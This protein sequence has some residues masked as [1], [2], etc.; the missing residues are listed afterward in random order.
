MTVLALVAGADA[1][2]VILHHLVRMI[3]VI[4]GAPIAARLAGVGPRVGPGGA[5]K[6]RTRD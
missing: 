4:L 3:V 2:F 6:P 5:D 1:G